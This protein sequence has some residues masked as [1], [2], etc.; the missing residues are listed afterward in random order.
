M[1][2]EQIHEDGVSKMMEH[3]D[4]WKEAPVWDKGSINEATKGWFKYLK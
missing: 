2:Y 4:Y 1:I 3:I